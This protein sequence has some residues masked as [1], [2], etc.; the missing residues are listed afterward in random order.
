MISSLGDQRP[1][2]SHSA[3][4]R[5]PMPSMNLLLCIS[6]CSI[7]CAFLENSNMELSGIQMTRGNTDIK[8]GR[9][10]DSIVTGLEPPGERDGS[11]TLELPHPLS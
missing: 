10:V 9:A 1:L 8:P 4:Y 6:I 7:A 11:G 5:E 3:Q 2:C